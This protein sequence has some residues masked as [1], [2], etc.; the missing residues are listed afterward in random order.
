[1]CKE[2]GT[3]GGPVIRAMSFGFKGR[4]EITEKSSPIQGAQEGILR[5][6][7]RVCKKP[8]RLCELRIFKGM[9]T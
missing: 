5:C 9:I 6:G 3:G 1:M 2:K 7:N 4:M 8:R